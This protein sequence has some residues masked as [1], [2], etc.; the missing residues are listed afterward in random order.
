MLAAKWKWSVSGLRENSSNS[1]YAVAWQK[2]PWFQVLEGVRELAGYL[3]LS[4]VLLRRI[5]WYKMSS[6]AAQKSSLQKSAGIPPS[7]RPSI[8]TMPTRPRKDRECHSMSER[9]ERKKERGWKGIERGIGLITHF[10]YHFSTRDPCF[11][12][13]TYLCISIWNLNQRY[14][15]PNL[16][17]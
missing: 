15:Y 16:Q 12:W 17:K 1:Y 8:A 2:R 11:A 9:R 5:K 10:E 13:L 6:A 4:L 7:L 14:N 3:S